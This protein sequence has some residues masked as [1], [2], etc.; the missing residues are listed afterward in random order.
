VSYDG[1]KADQVD[2]LL[3]DIPQ[4][5]LLK[6]KAIDPSIFAYSRLARVFAKAQASS[7]RTVREFLIRTV[8]AL[9]GHTR[10][11]ALDESY[12]GIVIANGEGTWRS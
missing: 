12:C 1:T 8:M 7:E 4:S 2:R 9:Y 5:F 6:L 10:K 11:S 3:A